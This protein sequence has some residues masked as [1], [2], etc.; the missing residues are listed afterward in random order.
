MNDFKICINEWRCVLVA[1]IAH[2]LHIYLRSIA[3]DGGV[4]AHSVHKFKPFSIHLMHGIY[5]GETRIFYF[6]AD[7][8]FLNRIVVYRVSYQCE[9]QYSFLINNLKKP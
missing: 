3:V 8:I 9:G 5:D 1:S 2:N 7:V 6:V 4:S